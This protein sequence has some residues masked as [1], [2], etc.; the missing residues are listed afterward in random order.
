MKK[1]KISI[2][3]FLI[4]LCSST[5]VFSKYDLNRKI[6]IAKIEIDCTPPKLQVDYSTTEITE[7][8]ITVT[9]ISNE[10]LQE[11]EGFSLSND[12]MT[13]TKTYSK[14]I[15]EKIEVK[16]LSGNITTQ[17]ITVSN[18]DKEEPK[19]K[20]E[21]IV[22]YVI[23][24]PTIINSSTKIY[25]KIIVTDDCQIIDQLKL[26]DINVLVGNKKPIIEER[27]I[28]NTIQGK[29]ESIYKLTLSGIDS[30]GDLVITIPKGKI[31]DGVGHESQYVEFNTGIKIEKH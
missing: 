24:S 20:I 28:S 15:E 14:N 19:I 30:E 26:A 7:D 18:I 1:I 8:D 29:T 6:Q 12:K 2:V 11:V 4:I 9:I 5:Y 3:I 23:N 17:E 25:F 21:Y 27:A 31:K 22:G 13:L 10:E 16:D